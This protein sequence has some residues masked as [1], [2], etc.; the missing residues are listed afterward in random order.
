MIDWTLAVKIPLPG[1]WAARPLYRL[2]AEN[3]ETAICIETVPDNDPRAIEGHRIAPV[4]AIYRFLKSHTILVPEIY[5]A[6]PVQGRLIMEDFGDESWGRILSAR[7]LSEGWDLNFYEL[8]V[9]IL[10]DFKAI[11]KDTSLSIPE[12]QNSYI[13]GRTIWYLEHYK[14]IMD[15]KVR[16]DFLRQW[17]ELLQKLHHEPVHFVHGDFHPGNLMKLPD[18]RIGILDVGGAFW[19]AGL[20]D[21][22]NLLEDVRRDVPEDIKQTMKQGYGLCE[23]CYAIL[24]AQFYMRLLGQMTRRGMD[25]PARIPETLAHLVDHFQILK[26]LRPLVLS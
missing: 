16:I 25:I 21:L 15:K 12:F 5:E 22:V 24:H 1:D 19:G 9:E 18:N 10:N 2:Q 6:D 17:D 11:K 13:F 4:A 26:P 3:G 23:D 8:A 7:R 14:K 20:Y